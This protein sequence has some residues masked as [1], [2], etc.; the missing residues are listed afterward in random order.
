[1]GKD[2]ESLYR[3]LAKILLLAAGLIVLLWFIFEVRGVLLLFAF[4]LILTLALNAPVASLERRGVP[5]VP[6]ALIVL[7]V[8]AGALALVGWFV[9]PRFVREATALVLA[10]PDFVIS[11]TNQLSSLL[12]EHPELQQGI[13]LDGQTASQL[14]PSLI[15]LVGEIWR[16]SL[17]ALLSLV[18]LVFFAAV[19]VYMLLNPRPLIRW[20][21]E[22]FPLHLREPATRA[23]AAGSRAVVGWVR[24]NMIVGAMEA[25]AAFVFLHMMGIPGALI[26]SVFTFFAEFV[27]RLG[28]Y[29]MTIPPVLVAFS[30]EPMSA[31]WVALFYVVLNEIMGDFVMPR[32]RASTMQLHAVFLLFVTLAMFVVFGLPGALIATP[33]AGFV[34]AYYV[35][36]YV[37]R[38]PE[39]TEMEQRIDAALHGGTV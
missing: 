32:V 9:I 34:K 33:L 27:P 5:R 6:A 23:F 15:D 20:Y 39:D 1:M 35:E 17:S 25:A 22:L 10:L 38:Q 4:A 12:E 31:L 21:F 28:P 2:G 8:V 18:V 26:W 13:L 7:V 14:V 37:A 24:S 30:I 19:V 3:T 11:F 29:L 16:Y 36:F